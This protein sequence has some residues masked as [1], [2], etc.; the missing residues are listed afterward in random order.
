MLAYTPSGAFD[1][2]FHKLVVRV[3]RGGAKV[4]SHTG[5]VAREDEPVVNRT[6]EEEIAAAAKSP[7]TKRDIDVSPNVTMRFG[8][9]NKAQISVD[10]LIDGKTLHFTQ[11]GNNYK[12]SLDVV[13]FLFNQSGQKKGGLSQTLNL[14]LNP[15]QYRKTL[16]EGIPYSANLELPAGYYQVRC[17]VREASSGSLG[18]FSKYLEIPDLTKGKMAM[19]SIFL[20]AVDSKG[21]AKPTPLFASR[22]LTRQQELRYAALVYNPKLKDGKP[23]VRSS[24]YISQGN[25][26]LFSEVDQPVEAPSGSMTASMTAKIG[27]IVLS[28]V[29]LGRYLLTV[30]I[31]DPLADKNNQPEARSV[32]FILK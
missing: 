2:K 1:R 19:S 15:D 26:M 21:D 25:K 8:A 16:A 14:D 20:F 31:T 12:T 27:Q 7:L 23:Q 11:S 4:Y 24:I 28:K 22:V 5:Y 6:K 9:D 30:V 13:G 17:V 18:T 10:M 32:D 3:K 29:P